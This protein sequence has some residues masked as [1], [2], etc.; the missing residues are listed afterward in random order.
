[1]RWARITYEGAF[2]HV[3]NRGIEG[4]AIFSEPGFKDRFI[5]IDFIDDLF[6]K[7]SQLSNSLGSIYKNAVKSRG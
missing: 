5:E 4:Q 1:M 7:K 3:M 2:H 6:G